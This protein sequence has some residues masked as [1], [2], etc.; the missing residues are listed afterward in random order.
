MSMLHMRRR[1]LNHDD[2]GYME[3]DLLVGIP[4]NRASLKCTSYV[5]VRTFLATP[6]E[7]LD[8]DTLSQMTPPQFLRACHIAEKSEK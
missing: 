1:P 2:D 8:Q 4:G 5:C 7:N 6:F 3:A